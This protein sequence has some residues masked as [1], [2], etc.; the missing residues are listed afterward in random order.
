MNALVSKHK[1][2]FVDGKLKKPFV[3][4][5]EEEHWLICNSMVMSWILN[6]V[7]KELH[8][9]V[10]YHDTKLGMWKELEECFSQGSRP[11]I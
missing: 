7:N 3:D 2:G 4:D 1:I 11:H 5:L 6:S 9:S 10:V 8:E